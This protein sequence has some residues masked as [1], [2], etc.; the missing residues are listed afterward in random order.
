MLCWTY[1]YEL[2]RCYSKR[3]Y[4]PLLAEG[5]RLTSIREPVQV[6]DQQGIN[7][8]VNSAKPIYKSDILHQLQK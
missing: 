4:R 3:K 6:L 5:V 7:A 8:A 1:E 2:K